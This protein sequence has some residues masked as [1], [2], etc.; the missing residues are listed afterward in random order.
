MSVE[1]IALITKN[2]REGIMPAIADSFVELYKA[3]KGIVDVYITT[4]TPLENATREKILAKVSTLVG[5]ELVTHEAVDPKL[6][7]GFTVKINDKLMDASIA[8]QFRNLKNIL[9]N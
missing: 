3:H 8:S 9:L 6:I 1:F 5:G 7:G 4:A 2:S